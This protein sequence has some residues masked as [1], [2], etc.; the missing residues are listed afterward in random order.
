MRFSK[1]TPDDLHNV[2][3]STTNETKYR[4]SKR[5]PVLQGVLKKHSKYNARRPIGA[6]ASKKAT[7]NVVF[8][9]TIQ[10]FN[11]E[12]LL[13]R[14][15]LKVRRKLMPDWKRLSN[16]SEYI[17]LGTSVVEAW[18]IPFRLIHER[19]VH[20]VDVFTDVTLIVD[21]IRMRWLRHVMKEE[22]PEEVIKQ[23][24]RYFGLPF[25]IDV[26]SV[27]LLYIL[28]LTTGT[29]FENEAWWIVMSIL[30]THRVLR[31]FKYF[32]LKEMDIHVD[33]RKM[34]AIKFSLLL[35]GAAHWV[36]SFW[37]YVA[38]LYGDDATTWIDEYEIVDPCYNRDTASEAYSTILVMY[39]GFNGLT[40]LGYQGILPSNA[41]EVVYGVF[42]MFLQVIFYAYILG[43]IFHYLIRKDEDME[44]RARELKAIESYAIEHHLPENLYARLKTYFSFQHQ[45]QSSSTV[46]VMKKV[47][48][49][50]QMKI[51]SHLYSSVI[52]KVV[53]LESQNQ[54]FK[55]ALMSKLH[56]MYLMPTETLAQIGDMSRELYFVANGVIDVV[57]EDGQIVESISS[58]RERDPIVGTLSFFVGIP[59]QHMFRASSIS[60][61]TVLVLPAEDYEALSNTYPDEHES[62]L[63]CVLAEFGLSKFGEDLGEDL[64][65]KTAQTRDDET[66]I[67]TFVQQRESVR[68]TLMKKYELSL[69]NLANA[70]RSNDVSSV[71]ELLSHGLDVDIS[72]YDDRGV[73][74][75]AAKDGRQ[76]IVEMLIEFGASVNIRDN[77]D[78]TPLQISVM[79]GHYGVA[80]S[81][82]RHGGEILSPNPG[83]LLCDSAHRGDIARLKAYIDHGIP[84]DTPNYDKITAFHIAAHAGNVRVMEYL[85]SFKNK[86]NARDRWGRTPLEAAVEKK[87]ALVAAMLFEQGG[88]VT[89]KFAVHHLCSAA[90]RGDEVL[91]SLLIRSGIDVNLTQYDKRTALHFAAAA[92]HL[93][94]VDY[95]LHANADGKMRDRYGMAP[96]DYALKYTHFDVAKLISA[97]CTVECSEDDAQKLEAI[98]IDQVWAKT[99][100]SRGQQPKLSKQDD[101]VNFLQRQR[102]RLDGQMELLMA[103]ELKLRDYTSIE[104]LRE[105]KTFEQRLHDGE[106]A[107]REIPP[108]I[109]K[110]LI[111]R[112][113]NRL[114]LNSFLLSEALEQLRQEVALFYG[115]VRSL[116]PEN[117]QAVLAQMGVFAQFEHC[118]TIWKSWRRAE[119]RSYGSFTFIDLLIHPSF[120]KAV[121]RYDGGVDPPAITRAYVIIKEFLAV[122]DENVHGVIERDRL[123]L[124]Q[125]ELNRMEG[126]DVGSRVLANRFAAILQDDGPEAEAEE[127]GRRQSILSL[128]QLEQQK[129]PDIHRRAI[130]GAILGWL[131]VPWGHGVDDLARNGGNDD[132]SEADDISIEDAESGWRTRRSGKSDGK[133]SS[134]LAT[135]RKGLE[136][137][138]SLIQPVEELPVGLEIAY[139][140]GRMLSFV[141]DEVEQ[142]NFSKQT[143]VAR[144]FVMVAG[145]KSRQPLDI[146]KVCRLVVTLATS[147][148]SDLYVAQVIAGALTSNLTLPYD[149]WQRCCATIAAFNDVG[150]IGAGNSFDR[151]RESFILSPTSLVI[152]AFRALICV[153][154]FYYLMAVPYRL[155]FLVQVPGDKEYGL[156]S[157]TFD[158]VADGFVYLFM[159]S[160]FFT[161]YVNENSVVVYDL[162]KI[163]DHY[164]TTDFVLDLVSMTPLDLLAVA[165][166]ASVESLAWLRTPRLIQTRFFL[167][168]L[169]GMIKDASIFRSVVVLFVVL[170][171]L[172]HILACGWF[173]LAGQIGFDDGSWYSRYD[174]YGGNNGTTYTSVPEYLLS[175]YWIASVISAMGTGGV[176]P[177]HAAE[178]VY[179]IIALL[180]NLTMY[181]FILGEISS[182]V[183]KQ[184]EQLVV[185]RSGLLTIE[186]Y[187]RSHAFPPD[188][189]HEIRTQLVSA[190]NSYQ[191]FESET[192]QIFDSLSQ[193]LKVEVAKVISRSALERL[194]LFN[195]CSENFLDSVSV[196]LRESTFPAEQ[197]IFRCN[198]ACTDLYIVTRGEVDITSSSDTT[199][200]VIEAIVGPG[201]EVGALE[202]IFNV[203]HTNN[204]RAGV[205]GASVFLLPKDQFDPLL[206]FYPAEEDRLTKNLLAELE[207]TQLNSARTSNSGHASSAVFTTSLSGAG[208][209]MGEESKL[210]HTISQAKLNKLIERATSMNNAAAKGDIAQL[211]NLLKTSA[212]FDVNIGDANNRLP[213][214]VAASRGLVETVGWLL[215]QGANADSADA[216]GNTPLMDAVRGNHAEVAAL[217]RQAGAT[218]PSDQQLVTE[219]LQESSKGDL[220]RVQLYVENGVPA[221]ACDANKRTPLHV[222]A[223]SGHLEVVKYLVDLSA[224]INPLDV[225]H[226]TPLEDA[227]KCERAAVQQFLADIGGKLNESNVA[228]T[229]C[230]VAFRDDVEK[231]RILVKAGTDVNTA[232][233]DFRTCLHIAAAEGHLDMVTYLLTIKDLEVNPIDGM[234]NT[235]YDDAVRHD[236]RVIALL[237]GENHGI[238]GKHHA[239][240]AR[241]DWIA[242]AVASR[243][244]QRQIEWKALSELETLQSQYL[245]H[246]EG[247]EARFSLLITQLRK[248]MTEVVEVR[249]LKPQQ[250]AGA[251]GVA[252][253]NKTAR[254]LNT[255]R[256]QN[257][258]RGQNTARAQRASYFS[259]PAEARIRRTRMTSAKGANY[260]RGSAAR[261]IQTVREVARDALYRGVDSTKKL[262]NLVTWIRNEGC[263][264]NLGDDP[265]NQEF[266]GLVQTARL[267]IRSLGIIAQ[268]HDFAAKSEKQ[269]EI[270]LGVVR[271]TDHNIKMSMFRLAKNTLAT[272][273]YAWKEI[274]VKARKANQEVKLDADG[275][276][277][278]SEANERKAQTIADKEKLIKSLQG[279]MNQDSND[280]AAVSALKRT[281]ES[282]TANFSLHFPNFLPNTGG[283]AMP[284]PPAVEGEGSGSGSGQDPTTLQSSGSGSRASGS[285]SGETRSGSDAPFLVK[286]SARSEMSAATGLTAGTAAATGARGAADDGEHDSVHEGCATPARMPELP[287]QSQTFTFSRLQG[288]PPVV[289]PSKDAP[290]ENGNTALEPSSVDVQSVLSRI[291]NTSVLKSGAAG[292]LAVG[293]GE[294]FRR[295]PV[296]SSVSKADIQT[297]P[298]SRSTSMAGLANARGGPRRTTSVAVMGGPRGGPGAVTSQGRGRGSPKKA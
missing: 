16:L 262:V 175:F 70:V 264:A 20:V 40:N 255:A 290:V 293:K 47:P 223:S 120:V 24:E 206:K 119:A 217:L 150:C 143:D 288:L 249:E 65:T 244:V 59:Q 181:A 82:G 197:Y 109:Q 258:A 189:E 71:Q 160:K 140:I 18:R 239:I 103:L 64:A 182:L 280:T 153:I 12:P 95:L 67:Q 224:D 219:L 28:Y 286:D 91:L 2:S 73:L 75:L 161:G 77:H 233:P 200:D 297:T 123:K 209:G 126:M 115:G 225:W 106:L 171:C 122:F 236:H 259:R 81:L 145:D 247:S 208:G 121:M 192:S 53:M 56:A 48:Q 269:I 43:T 104:I 49:A 72:N 273:F 1:V 298:L 23:S 294:S 141:V 118:R 54:T 156:S 93:T 263:S 252:A 203:R 29:S 287:V 8:A 282:S 261:Y 248:V 256:G 107:F 116:T 283:P 39:W 253:G 267:M 170:F 277:I 13:Q 213:I 63:N 88:L 30:R 32:R 27:L 266:D 89:E 26:L 230:W 6:E 97:V 155:V 159:L 111:R 3:T 278:L 85:S 157:F 178:L 4:R 83:Q 5:A 142:P 214:H 193:V 250:Q 185:A 201:G 135:A 127:D 292:T 38:F 227:M 251:A 195:G 35:F 179:A 136:F 226:N 96:I 260:R 187:I 84:P 105:E 205:Y 79:N 198:E 272:A 191:S 216:Y 237:L 194:S 166:G 229:L 133:H 240:E 169:R 92:G 186:S 44:R 176:Y 184:D 173:F 131:E 99:K 167:S 147:G 36:G 19:R 98:S 80:E 291:R 151:D 100:Q 281:Q 271:D 202:F 86:L 235:P 78:N 210:L 241:V 117:L 279:T 289:L 74:H 22:T 162:S 108:E 228:E 110:R 238:S 234:G 246:L 274:A 257:A 212:D 58:D 37:F 270:I 196:L 215:S 132:A 204:A 296:K 285:A 158:Y 114:V 232:D 10:A 174:G 55:E 50:L 183:L 14:L 139:W 76:H 168:F 231:L 164:L 66:N 45:K 211:E 113:L 190:S 25:S 129:K 61:V 41:G 102:Q 199:T 69:S 295:S 276:V 94:A 138:D 165:T 268:Q 265:V 220:A 11:S 188:L 62:L 60:D 21:M 254:G 90:R 137:G 31:L 52:N 87:N 42:V 275:M 15:F 57:D 243:I 152:R 101:F 125:G 242:K 34:S 51:A 68:A 9:D 172:I 154:S 146:M 163:R 124:V 17:Q 207:G 222:A 221:D 134:L 46:S 177:S 128:S 245:E 33:I 112:R 130:V 149:S 218:L 180:I 7:R 144:L 284:S 148:W